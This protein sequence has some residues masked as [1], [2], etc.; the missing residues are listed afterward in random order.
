MHDRA[1]EL[2]DRWDAVAR[3]L[4]DTHESRATTAPPRWVRW[5]QRGLWVAVALAAIG[6]LTIEVGEAG[7]RRPLLERIVS[8]SSRTSP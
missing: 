5:A 1:D 8:G 4:I 6:L 2:L 3:S 7:S